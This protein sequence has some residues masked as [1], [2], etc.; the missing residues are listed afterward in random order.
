ML[1]LFLT[2]QT[3]GHSSWC[4]Q[5]GLFPFAFTGSHSSLYNQP[6][7][8]LR[9]QGALCGLKR[10]ASQMS[11]ANQSS[12]ISRGSNASGA[13]ADSKVKSP[14]VMHHIQLER[15][16][17]QTQHALSSQCFTPA[18]HTHTTCHTWH[19]ESRIANT[20]SQQRAMTI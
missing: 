19:C 7:L 4:L 14:Q 6:C 11:S 1:Y 18:C 17:I 5:G 9:V 16:S 20:M 15:L 8:C 10:K 2:V 3:T 13:S 12:A